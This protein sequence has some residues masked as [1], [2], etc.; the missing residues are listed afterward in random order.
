MILELD[1]IKEHYC[2]EEGFD[3]IIALTKGKKVFLNALRFERNSKK[4]YV[5]IDKASELGLT[6]LRTVKQQFIHNINSLF[7]EKF[8]KLVLTEKIDF[9]NK[10]ETLYD[11]DSL[12]VVKELK[13]LC[14]SGTIRYEKLALKTHS[15]D[16]RDEGYHK[17]GMEEI[18]YIFDPFYISM[19]FD[20]GEFS[21]LGKRA[22]INA[23]GRKAL[24]EGILTRSYSCGDYSRLL[25]VLEDA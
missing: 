3:R 14:P 9:F 17:A 8:G 10:V 22:M 25:T 13:F 18:S 23:S 6:N 5:L 16:L 1:A 12:G 24:T 21:L 20:H 15:H 2:I 7:E 11:D 4:L 19:S